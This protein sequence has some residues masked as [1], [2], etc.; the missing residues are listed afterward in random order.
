MTRPVRLAVAAVLTP[1]LGVMLAGC[2]SPSPGPTS[3]SAPTPTPPGPSATGGATGGPGGGS[4]ALLAIYY[5][6]ADRGTPKLVREFHRLPVAADTA[7]AKA[8]AAVKEMLRPSALDSDYKTL[9]PT[10]ATVRGVSVSGDVTTVDLS[11]VSTGNVGAIGEAQAV[12]QLVWTVT[13]ATGLP[14]VQ[15]KRDGKVV[16]S[17]WGHVTVDKPLRRAAAADTLHAVWVIAPQHGERTGGDVTVHLAGIVFEATVN[18]DVLQGGTVV[19]HGVVTLDPGRP[20]QGEAKV[21]V[22]LAPGTYV[23]QAYEVSAKDGSR[24][25]IDNHT[26]TVA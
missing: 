9:W 7:T 16:E 14:Q 17:L 10:S 20:A 18:Y 15:I 3:S 6:L 19:K 25:H 13:A 11:G 22:R 26:F 8:T 2:P 1:V 4:T 24:L 21:T 12:Q 5:T 23:I